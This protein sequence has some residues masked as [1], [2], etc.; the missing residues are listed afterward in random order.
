M[1]DQHDDD[2][3]SAIGKPM[4]FRVLAP[5]ERGFMDVTIEPTTAL[6]EAGMLEGAQQYARA[7][8][9]DRHEVHQV[10]F[11]Y[12]PGNGSTV[13]A[14]AM[15]IRPECDPADPDPQSWISEGVQALCRGQ[16]VTSIVHVNE[17]WFS[18]EAVHTR[19]RAS[20]ASDRQEWVWILL[21]STGLPRQH[22]GV[23]AVIDRSVEPPALSEFKPIPYSEMPSFSL[24][25]RFAYLIDHAKPV[26]A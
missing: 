4:R 5:M 12:S 7:I 3:D 2:D 21:E 26:D 23:Y 10:F 1:S 13:G 17:M 19:G 20:Q 24:G 15:L 18:R 22:A 6:A 16:G 9:H 8:W 25:G 11:M 14:A